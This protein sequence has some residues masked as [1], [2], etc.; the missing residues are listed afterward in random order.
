M[1]QED[2]VMSDLPCM[3]ESDVKTANGFLSTPQVR[4]WNAGLLFSVN[5]NVQA[6][7]D[8]AFQHLNVSCPSV[9]DI[10][11]AKRRAEYLAGRVLA[12]AASHIFTGT[13]VVFPPG[14]GGAP[15]WPAGMS[16]SISHSHGRALCL[17]RAGDNLVIGVDIEKIAEPGLL[18]AI[19]D[20]AV[21]PEEEALLL[22]APMDKSTGLTMLFSAKETIFKALY[23]TVQ[24]FFGF[25]TA[26]LCT[27][28][29]RDKMTL[30]LGENLAPRWRAGHIISV[31]CQCQGDFVLT[32]IMLQ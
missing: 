25:E 28:P 23:P 6:Y 14:E 1:N 9:L 26:R 13:A 12:R 20:L 5:Y 10:A 21:S 4:P 19:V 11:V 15:R 32:S 2:A 22:D 30:R 24:R 8:S 29:A 27:V 16:G 3:L 17:A 7:K 18:K 31:C